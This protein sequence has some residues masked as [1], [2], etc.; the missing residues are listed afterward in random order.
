MSP[1]PPIRIAT[2]P[3]IEAD[4]QGLIG[5]RDLPPGHPAHYSKTQYEADAELIIHFVNNV[6]IYGK[7]QFFQHIAHKRVYWLARGVLQTAP[8]S[9]VQSLERR[10]RPYRLGGELFQWLTED[11][12][13]RLWVKRFSAGPSARRAESDPLPGSEDIPQQHRERMLLK[14]SGGQSRVQRF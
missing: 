8:E 3:W 14:R 10:N 7:Y 6:N 12:S 1:P 11:Q 5:Q 4:Q 2:R 13:F 9:K